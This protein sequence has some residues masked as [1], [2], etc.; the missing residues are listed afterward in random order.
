MLAMVP[1]CVPLTLPASSHPVLKMASGTYDMELLRIHETPGRPREGK[2]K[3]FS[4]FLDY[5]KEGL[6]LFSENQKSQKQRETMA[7]DLPFIN[8]TA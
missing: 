6:I 7:R 1:K 2:G 3:C 8:T 4:M 5:L